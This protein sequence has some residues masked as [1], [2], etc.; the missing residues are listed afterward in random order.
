MSFESLEPQP[1]GSHCVIMCVERMYVYT[2][3]TN[4]RM[5]WL[6]IMHEYVKII[7]EFKRNICTQTHKEAHL[8]VELEHWQQ[9]ISAF[10]SILLPV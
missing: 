3:L 7:Q 6:L 8:R 4:M 9:E 2:K 1:F 5:F 10:Y